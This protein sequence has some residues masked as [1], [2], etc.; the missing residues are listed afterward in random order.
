MWRKEFYCKK[1]DF[2]FI[3]KGVTDN[4]QTGPE[5]GRVLVISPPGLK[6]L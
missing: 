3:P 5:G 1:G 4:Y 6:I 2:V